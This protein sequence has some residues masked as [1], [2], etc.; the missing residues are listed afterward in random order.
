VQFD[1]KR[2]D[3]LS[4]EDESPLMEKSM[5]TKN[6]YETLGTPGSQNQE[7]ESQLSMRHLSEGGIAMR[8]TDPVASQFNMLN[9]YIGIALIALPKA[10]SDVGFVAA[11]IGLIAVNF[12]SLGAS[13]FL[14][15]ARNR[16]KKQ[17]IIDFPDMA[18]VTYGPMMKR[19]SESILIL[20]N[21][22]FVMA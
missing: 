4:F 5:V 12:L 8:T 21:T 6:N 15:K 2:D 9:M 20:A 22:T 13:Y 7:S 3:D 16:F 18:N 17:R 11:F 10:V 14:L 1:N 19:F